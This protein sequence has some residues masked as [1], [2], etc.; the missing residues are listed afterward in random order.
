MGQLN[1][2][3]VPQI[4]IF[5]RT[6]LGALYL[7]S[8]GL[9]DPQL[10]IQVYVSEWVSDRS[11]P[12]KKCRSIYTHL[13][14]LSSILFRPHYHYYYASDLI[15]NANLC[16]CSWKIPFQQNL[17][18]IIELWTLHSTMCLRE[19]NPD[20]AIEIAPKV[21]ENNLVEFGIFA[22]SRLRYIHSVEK[23]PSTHSHHT[24]PP[25]QSPCPCKCG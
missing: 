21:I 8:S 23:S 17:H 16:A 1:L 18:P 15:S 6:L 5:T 12:L 20:S 4:I 22:F 3:H 25:S 9:A 14:W 19:K 7:I 2:D 10:S 11:G 24:R 13:L